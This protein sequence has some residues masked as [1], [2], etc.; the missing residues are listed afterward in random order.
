M[1]LLNSMNDA[2]CVRDNVKG[3]QPRNSNE[4][5]SRESTYSGIHIAA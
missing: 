4:K 3:C 1:C 5:K 2:K